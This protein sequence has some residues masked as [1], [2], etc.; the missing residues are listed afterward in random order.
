MKTILAVILY[1]V[2]VFGLGALAAPWV[3]HLAHQL[4]DWP[5]R[6][7]FDR[8]LLVIAIAGIWPLLRV[9]GLRSWREV[10]YPSIP[11]WW[12]YL[13]AGLGLGLLS[14]GVG[15]IPLFESL[16]C[17]GS[18]VK[19]LSFA[20]TGLVVGL[21]EETFFRGGLQNALQQRIPVVWAVFIVSGIYS[22][23]HFLKPPGINIPTEAVVWSSG[24]EHLGRVVDQSFRAPGVLRAVVTLWLACGVLGW[25]FVRMRSLYLS[26]GL[27][28][29]WVFSLKTVA[30]LGGGSLLENTMIWPVMVL[31][32]VGIEWWSRD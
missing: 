5:F 13:L 22:V 12:R 4:G 10:G 14:Y 19:L 32:I 11:A 9:V 16:Q 27:H 3:F 24:F 17:S 6:R 1:A 8:V 30:W 23:V 7:V 26:I 31:L 15:C 28:A 18:P 21:V 29:G 2:A 20:A 25:A